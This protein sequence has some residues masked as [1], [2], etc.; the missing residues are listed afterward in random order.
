MRDVSHPNT[1]QI[2]DDI[3]NFC[4]SPRNTVL[5]VVNSSGSEGKFQGLPLGP[6]S[7]NGS[8]SVRQRDMWIVYLCSS[9]VCLVFQSCPTF[10]NPW[11]VASQAPL[12]MGFLQAWILEWVS[13]PSP[14]G[15]SQPR[16][17]TQVSHT[18]GRLLTVWDTRKAQEYQYISSNQTLKSWNKQPW[19]ASGGE[20]DLLWL[21]LELRV[22]LLL[23]YHK[24]C[25]L[26]GNKHSFKAIVYQ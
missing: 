7:H 1:F 18:A 9:A 12:S 24:L 11:T 6:S 25:T 15:S 21:G 17:Q 5:L 22:H 2:F 19:N 4:S 23:N 8:H 20:Q 3:T 10:C 14:R 26:T 16:D 13:M